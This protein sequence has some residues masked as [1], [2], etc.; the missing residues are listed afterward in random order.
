LSLF[1][2]PSSKLVVITILAE[3]VLDLEQYP[4]LPVVELAH[5][6]VGEELVGKEVLVVG[7]DGLDEVPQELTL[8][9]SLKGRV[10]PDILIE[11][12][13]RRHQV[14]G[15]QRAD[16]RL[17]EVILDRVTHQ[18]VVDGLVGAVLRVGVLV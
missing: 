7:F 14:L 9:L 12:A 3:L 4:R 6:V 16:A 2:G 10:A 1:L 18:V 17:E 8:A 5:L 11:V 15:R 13:P